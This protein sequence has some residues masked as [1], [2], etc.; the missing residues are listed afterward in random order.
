MPIAGVLAALIRP[1]IGSAADAGANLLIN[2]ETTIVDELKLYETEA[3]DVLA[4]EF[5]AAI[6]TKSLGEKMASGEFRATIENV[7][8]E[9]K[10]QLGA[11]DTTIINTIVDRLSAIS[12][13]AAG[14]Q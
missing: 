14:V 2:D 8:T 1:L 11:I 9:I 13:S 6:P 12:A 3:V 4:N 7:A 5:E 10:G